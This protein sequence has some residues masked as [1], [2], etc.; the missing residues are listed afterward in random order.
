MSL[1]SFSLSEP[2]IAQGTP[3]TSNI[4][5]PPPKRT[6]IA[7]ADTAAVPEPR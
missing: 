1:S 4:K 6:A 7:V 2:A 3:Q 5:K